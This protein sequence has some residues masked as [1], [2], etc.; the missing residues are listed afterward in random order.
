M[1]LLKSASFGLFILILAVTVQAPDPIFLELQC[2]N[3]KRVSL[4]VRYALNHWVKVSGCN[5]VQQVTT[6]ARVWLDMNCKVEWNSPFVATITDLRD[7]FQNGDAQRNF[8]CNADQGTVQDVTFAVTG[9]TITPGNLITD[10]VTP[11]VYMSLTKSDGVTPVTAAHVGDN[12]C[13]FLYLDGSFVDD[14]SIQ[15]NTISMKSGGSTTILTGGGGMPGCQ[16]SDLWAEVEKIDETRMRVCFTVFGVLPPTGTATEQLFTATVNVCPADE[17]KD[18]YVAGCLAPTTA[19]TTAGGGGGGGRRRR[20]VDN[21]TTVSPEEVEV[22]TSLIILDTSDDS[23]SGNGNV[24]NGAQFGNNADAQQ[25]VANVKCEVCMKKSVL[26]GLIAFFVPALILAFA[27]S[28]CLYCRTRQLRRRKD[29]DET[30]IFTR[31]STSTLNS[32]FRGN[33]SFR[34]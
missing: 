5:K 15:V 27:A 1:D 12:L 34:A 33:P 17:F 19:P 16:S 4:R 6:N 9:P 30:D 31:R 25:Q 20:D 7:K 18:C 14:Y 2:H 13:M 23:D 3:N 21:T 11:T 10:T 29:I 24:G 28:F 32:S 26:Y 8:M 22:S